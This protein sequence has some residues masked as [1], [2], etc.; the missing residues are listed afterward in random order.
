MTTIALVAVD[1]A[2]CDTC[3]V[4]EIGDDRTEGVAV[5]GVAVQHFCV[6]HALSVLDGPK[7]MVSNSLYLESSVL[8]RCHRIV[9]ANERSGNIF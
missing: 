3:E 8:M 1:T 7:P 6:Q 5:M 9:V 2:D 4:L